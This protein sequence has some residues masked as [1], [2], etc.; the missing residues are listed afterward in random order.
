MLVTA[1]RCSLLLKT[2]SLEGLHA[3]RSSQTWAIQ[4]MSLLLSEDRP[5]LTQIS[6]L[7][8][9]LLAASCGRWDPVP[10]PG[11]E[12]MFPA[13]EAWCLNHWTTREVPDPAFQ[14]SFS[15]SS[16]VSTEARIACSAA[17]TG[18]GC[19]QLLLFLIFAE[20]ICLICWYT[21]SLIT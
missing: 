10:R 7:F 9:F 1:L 18:A 14:S 2:D 12:L 20:D 13:V 17:H 8:F 3:V 21:A 15:G 19:G 6:F 4:S 11:I 5:C 16:S